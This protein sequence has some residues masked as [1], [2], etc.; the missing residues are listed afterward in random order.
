MNELKKSLEQLIPKVRVTELKNSREVLEIVFLTTCIKKMIREGNTPSEADID[1]LVLTP[2]ND[3][4]ERLQR[5]ML[6]AVRQILIRQ[7]EVKAGIEY[8]K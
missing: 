6:T 7:R 3:I 4:P 1:Q 5:M 8:V 2:V